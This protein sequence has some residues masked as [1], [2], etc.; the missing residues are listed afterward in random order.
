MK[1]TADGSNEEACAAGS[2]GIGGI[3]ERCL[4]GKQ[5]NTGLTECESCERQHYNP[6]YGSGCQ[7]CD[8]GTTPD[9]RNGGVFCVPC[10]LEGM[11]DLIWIVTLRLTLKP[12]V[13]LLLFAS[14]VSRL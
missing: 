11:A 2:A 8:A 5:A 10:D 3:C 13:S 14:P 9:K 4:A 6:D 1:P 7:Q 12:V